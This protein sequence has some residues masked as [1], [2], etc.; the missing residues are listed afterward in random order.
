MLNDPKISVILPVYNVEKYLRECLDSIICQSYSNIEIICIEN[1][2]TDKSYEILEEYSIKDNRIIILK[3]PK[4]VSKARNKGLSYATGEF[5]IF[6]D[7]DDI[8]HV[9]LIKE[10]YCACV[11][12]SV[13]FAWCKILSFDDGEKFVANTSNN[14][15][16]KYDN[17]LNLMLDNSKFLYVGVWGKLYSRNSIKTLKFPEDITIAEDKFFSL[18]YVM[19]IKE[20]AFVHKSLY[21]YRQRENSAMSQ[22]NA[23]KF[24]QFIEGEKYILS[25][26]V[27]S[28]KDRKLKQKMMKKA[29]N[30]IFA[31]AITRPLKDLRLDYNEVISYTYEEAINLYKNKEYFSFLSLKKRF[32]VWLFVMKK[33]N[34]LKF[35]LSI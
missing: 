2:S 10:L 11:E 27:N 15:I 35:V 22:C 28:I 34:L 31:S 29:V 30:E 7:S 17:L 23:S 14:T 9:D 18:Y 6:I 32:I 16:K 33:F 20:G 25:N 26:I 19:N 24:I 12:N 5:I 13:E 3:S 21:G 4:G 1:G 8:I